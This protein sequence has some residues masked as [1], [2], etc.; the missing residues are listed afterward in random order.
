LHS[1]HHS[2]DQF[3]LM[4]MS[5]R[6]GASARTKALAK[7]AEAV[8]HRDAERIAREKAV[9]ESLA[10]FFQA[11]DQID[12]IRVAAERAGVP[13]D[14]AMR[15]AVRRLDHLGESRTGIAELTGLPLTRVR[16]YLA[17]DVAPQHL[18]NSGASASW[19]TNP[20]V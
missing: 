9:Q 11:Q 12:R 6:A 14:E 15:D 17:A 2:H 20:H 4:N 5:R 18:D 1:E 13:F 3:T 16:G 8:A 7:A 10:E 19:P